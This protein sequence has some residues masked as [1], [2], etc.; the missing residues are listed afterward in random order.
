MCV[1]ER[2]R[3]TDRHTDTDRQTDGEAAII[4]LVVFDVDLRRLVWRKEESEC[5]FVPT[6]ERE[7]E[8]R[9]GGGGGALL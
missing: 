8:R 9:G 7:R 4:V 1:C 5:V 2:E 6:H 3:Q